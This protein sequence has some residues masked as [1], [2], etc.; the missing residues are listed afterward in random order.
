MTNSTSHS[1]Q[2]HSLSAPVTPNFPSRFLCLKC[3]RIACRRFCA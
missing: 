3:V 2:I 1:H